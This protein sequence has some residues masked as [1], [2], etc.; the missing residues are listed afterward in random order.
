MSARV[1]RWD[2]FF[3]F[4]TDYKKKSFFYSLHLEQ[5]IKKKIDDNSVQM[6]RCEEDSPVD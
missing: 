4:D 1:K 3:Q 5:E 2:E 6:I